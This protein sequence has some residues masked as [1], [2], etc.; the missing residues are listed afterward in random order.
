MKRD[1]ML[2]YGIVAYFVALSSVAY[3]I[4]FFGNFAIARTIDAAAVVPLGEAL[5]VNTLLLLLF[6]IQHSGMARKPF[7]AWLERCVGRCHVRS[8]YVLLTGITIIV[9]LTLWQPIGG[10]L[11]MIQNQAMS[12]IVTAVYFFGWAVMFYATFL[13][14]H[15][16]MF[17]LKQAWSAYLK[18]D[19]EAPRLRTPGL[20]RRVR[21]PIYLGWLLVLWST[22]VMT[23]SHLVFAAGMTIYML[24]GIQLEERD[25]TLEL[26]EY[27]QYMRKVPMLL[28]SF[29]KHLLLEHD[30]EEAEFDQ[31]ASRIPGDGRPG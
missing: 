2:L 23:V 1:L 26:P 17:G 18:G 28:P 13:L 22:P 4:A 3:C 21:H 12:R 25:L 15:F 10:I 16:E 20:Y 30:G 9:T 14:D 7:R 8:T 31:Q 19:C 27:E 6:G 29:R 5:V 24:I 11:W